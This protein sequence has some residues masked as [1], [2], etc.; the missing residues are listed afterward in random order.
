MLRP[1]FVCF[2]ASAFALVTIAACGTEDVD[3][4]S[5]TA[6]SMPS[7][8]ESVRQPTEPT[9][10]DSGT[11]GASVA[12][13]APGQCPTYFQDG[14]GDGYGGTTTV[15][16]CTPLG[17]GWA[18]VSGDC[19][20]TNADVHP[21]Q[22]A[23]FVTA[24]GTT[25]PKSFDYDCNQQEELEASFPIAGTCQPSAGGTSACTGEGYLPATRTGTGVS[26]YCGSNNY[27]RCVLVNGACTPVTVENGIGGRPRVSCR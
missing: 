17:N 27:Q 18:T 4:N 25:P 23:F 26:P 12:P 1:H 3:P 7:P 9:L 6:T 19:D 2:L 5:G 22:T 13:D 14:D 11:D 20:D 15:T 16:S 21:G 24:F 10:A 8:P